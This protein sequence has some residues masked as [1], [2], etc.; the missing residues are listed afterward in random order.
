M[1]GTDA[2]VERAAARLDSQVGAD[3]DRFFRSRPA[4]ERRLPPPDRRAEFTMLRTTLDEDDVVAFRR[5]SAGILARQ[6][7]QRLS[8][9]VMLTVLLFISVAF[10][11][12]GDDVAK[13]VSSASP[14][15]DLRGKRAKQV[16]RLLRP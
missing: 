10:D 6:R 4:G 8:V 15:F 11:E 2:A 13:Q 12:S 5:R 16:K 7:G 14:A 9:A 1:A 3:V